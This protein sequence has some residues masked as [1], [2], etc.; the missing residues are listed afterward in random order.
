MD[1]M[2]RVLGTGIFNLDTIVIREYPQGPENRT[3][4][5]KTVAEEVGG[6]CGNVMCMLSHFGWEA[7]PLAVL[8]TTEEGYRM[9]ES[10]K[11]YGCNMRFVSNVEGGGTT[12]L[13]VTHKMEPDGSPT[14]SV[15]SGSPGSR[16]PRRHFLRMRDEAP[17]FLASLDFVPDVFF[18]DDS[19]A[20][21]R[22]LAKT[23]R[24]KGSLVYFEPSSMK[25]KKD[26]DSVEVS[27]VV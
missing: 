10:M 5:E 2:K 6:T 8:D 7:Y 14:V 23:L 1:N 3:F 12:L 19:A 16:Y 25:E 24:E 11:D 17:A 26:F 21:H 22:L 20:G 9:A 13:K 18:F 15:R 4:I 27:D